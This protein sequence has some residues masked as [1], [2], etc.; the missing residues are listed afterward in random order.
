MAATFDLAILTP[1][2]TVFEG[3]AGYVQVPGSGGYLG[4]L[5]HHA[6]LVTALARGTLTVRKPGGEELQWAVS[7][8]F[9][10][11]SANRATV[12]AD[13]VGEGQPSQGG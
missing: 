1:E 8:G 6:A 13:E 9:F 12:L 11:V 10:E 7:G 2:K 3:P 4:V 5:A